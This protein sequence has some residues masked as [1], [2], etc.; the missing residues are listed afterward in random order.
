MEAREQAKKRVV[1]FVNQTQKGCEKAICLADFC[2]KNPGR[3]VWRDFHG[4]TPTDALEKISKHP[5]GPTAIWLCE[6]DGDIGDFSNDL[7]LKKLDAKD[8]DF[9]QDEYPRFLSRVE[10]LGMGFLT[11]GT[12]GIDSPIN[13]NLL[14][15]VCDRIQEMPADKKATML[16][17]LKIYRVV[18]L[19]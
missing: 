3:V 17:Q 10:G 14:Y 5:K 15:E 18:R 2:K 6:D 7:L 8:W 11:Q 12:P 9:F 16:D 4:L 1:K 19:Y 13:F